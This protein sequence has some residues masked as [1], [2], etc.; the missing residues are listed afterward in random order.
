MRKVKRRRPKSRKNKRH[1]GIGPLVTFFLLSVYRLL[2]YRPV[3]LV[4]CALG[5]GY[6]IYDNGYHNYLL[7]QYDRFSE[8][9]IH[10]TS[11][12]SG[13]VLKDVYLEGQHYAKDADIIQSM[14][15]QIGDPLMHIDIQDI[16]T[17]LEA[18]PWIRY[19]IVERIY[20]HTLR[21]RV[22]ERK[23]V[24]LWQYENQVQLIDSTGFVIPE[25]DLKPFSDLILLV[26][27]D[28]PAHTDS[29]MAILDSSP[30]VTKMVSS[31]I[32]VSKRRWNIRLHN[33]IEIKL[34]ETHPEEAW[35]H[36]LTLHKKTNILN[37][38]VQSIDL[39]IPQKMYTKPGNSS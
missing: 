7:L 17:K 11:N 30:A 34:P 20:P 21:I 38:A 27:E 19:A 29:L 15:L 8:D 2:R 39:R 9:L 12:K 32:R 36:L 16:K 3:V 22:V 31:A 5:F 25:T 37:S 35:E 14:D 24:A 28:A 10:T 26:G 6:W 23:P 13:L 33:G 1:V 18:L 4:L